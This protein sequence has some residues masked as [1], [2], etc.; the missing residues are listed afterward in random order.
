[1]GSGEEV[2]RIERIRSADGVPVLYETLYLPKRIFKDLTESIVKNSLYNYIEKELKL[3]INFSIQSIE[4]VN[5][6]QTVSNYLG[7]ALDYAVLHIT[8][9]TFLDNG[10]PFEYVSSYYRADQYRFIQHAFR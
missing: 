6:N 8:L 2:Y 3:S 5:A 1:L 7:I 10:H 9:N 4:A